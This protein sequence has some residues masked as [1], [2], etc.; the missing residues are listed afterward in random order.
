MKIV[1]TELALYESKHECV[2][3]ENVFSPLSEVCDD[4]VSL[5]YDVYTYCRLVFF[6]DDLSYF[7]N[8]LGPAPCSL[9]HAP[10][11]LLFFLPG[12]AMQ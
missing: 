11:S 5:I 7:R 1:Y 8:I 10:C 6:V 2:R 4:T 9:L 12:H 3:T